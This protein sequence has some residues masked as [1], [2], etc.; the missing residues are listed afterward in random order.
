MDHLIGDLSRSKKIASQLQEKNSPNQSTTSLEKDPLL[1]P[2]ELKASPRMVNRMQK[3]MFL[4]RKIAEEGLLQASP[5][6]QR[7]PKS[8]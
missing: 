5:R 1:F 8:K 7:S 2:S 6:E 3:Q 4:K